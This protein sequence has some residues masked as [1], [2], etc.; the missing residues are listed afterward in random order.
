MA[1]PTVPRPR[2]PR[3]NALVPGR[4]VPGRKRNQAAGQPDRIVP[5]A[6]VDCAVYRNGYRQPGFSDWRAAA[7]EVDTDDDAFMWIGL[8]EPT[9]EQIAGIAERFEL[10]PLAVEDVVLA[11]QRPKMDTYGDQLF[12]VVKTVYYDES[13]PT[14]SAEVVETGEVMIFLGRNFV[15]TA[16][17]GEHGELHSLREK[18]QG[19][20]ELLALGPSAVLHGILDS[21]VDSYVDVCRALDSDIDETETA[22]FSSS[23]KAMNSD[24]IYV[25]K[26]EVQELRRATAPLGPVLHQLSH[27]HVHH[28]V[29]E[30]RDYFRDVE[31]HLTGVVDRVG[32]FDDMLS[33]LVSANLARVSVMQNEDMRKISAWVAIAA[34]PTML[35][36]IYGMTFDHMPE[37]HWTFGYP[38]VIAVMATFCGLLYRAFKRNGWL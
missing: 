13:L 33:S 21:A 2:V 7:D 4:L 3:P 19:N 37:L 9:A 8:Y 25:L 5:S 10:H 20:P 24:V 36:G 31:D 15:I 16:R 32:G 23:K 1:V 29:P 17:H 30:V 28:V 14:G 26:R 11:H 18:L 27:G 12:V 35:A 38:F 6:V 22:V 34:V